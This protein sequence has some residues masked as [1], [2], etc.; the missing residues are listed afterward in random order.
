LAKEKALDLLNRSE[1]CRFL[2]H[3]KLAAKG[4]G[5]AG[6][7]EALDELE[8]EGL[9]DDRRYAFAWTRSRSISRHEGRS[10]LLAELRAR[11][12]AHPT[13]RA[14]LDDF[15]EE[16]PE[17]ECC[18]KAIEKYNRTGSV[19]KAPIE[20]HLQRLGFSNSLIRECLST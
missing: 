11:G 16:T 14:A 4:Y 8:S 2:L 9:L 3:R 18:Q 10:K 17:E 19:H 13:A 7:D 1:Q 12:I 20:I 15:F 6:I 5:E